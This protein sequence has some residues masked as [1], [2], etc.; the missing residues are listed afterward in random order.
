MVVC[1]GSCAYVQASPPVAGSLELLPLLLQP[2]DSELLKP[3][4]QE[5]QQQGPQPE[6]GADAGRAAKRPWRGPGS[7]RRVAAKAP[8]AGPAGKGQRAGGSG[9]DSD[10]RRGDSSC[11]HALQGLRLQA[12]IFR[13]NAEQ[14]AA[15]GDEEDVCLVGAI[16]DVSDCCQRVQEVGGRHSPLGRGRGAFTEGPLPRR[17]HI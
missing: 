10:A 14:L 12:D 4:P 5:Q 2:A 15:E 11:W 8:A 17:P 7:A 16:L 13:R 1:T 6:Q 3:P 9:D